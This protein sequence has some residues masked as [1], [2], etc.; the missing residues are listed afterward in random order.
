MET[1]IKELLKKLAAPF[2]ESAIKWR[3]AVSGLN[4]KGEPFVLAVPYIDARA[5]QSRLDDVI[6]AENWMAEYR[7]GAN[8]GTMCKLSLRIGGEWIAKEDGADLT[9]IE[10]IKG[11][12][13]NAYR[14]C[15]VVWGVGR[16]LYKLSSMY[17]TIAENGAYKGSARDRSNNSWVNFRWNAPKLPASALPE[18]NLKVLPGDKPAAEN[19]APVKSMPAGKAPQAS[20]AKAEI[21]IE[22]VPTS[23][24]ELFA[25][26]Q[27]SDAKGLDLCKR[28]NY[29]FA[30]VERILND[31]RLEPAAVGS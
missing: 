6:G 9:E 14:R 31:I 2:P 1:Q 28:K 13:S 4:G 17:G 25:E 30:E 8:N 12:I 18:M 29:D 5:I 19:K 24:R 22:D 16:Y 21:K 3:A 26:L 27:I 11:G 10:P 15:A 20:A 23:L 7:Q